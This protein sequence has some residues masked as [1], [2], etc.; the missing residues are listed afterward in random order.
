MIWEN[1]FKNPPAKNRIKPFWFWNGDMNEE[2]IDIQLKEMADKGLGGVFIC[3]RQGLK[4][5]YLSK[6]W[7]ERVKYASERAEEYGLEVWLYDEYPY[8]SGMSGG[9]VLIKNPDAVQLSVSCK[10]FVVENGGEIEFNLGWH[11]ILYAKAFPMKDDCICFDDPIS[12][13]DDIGNLQTQEIYQAQDGLTSYNKK[14]FFTYGPQHILKTRLPEGKWKIMTYHAVAIYDNFKYFGKYFDP[15][16]KEAVKTFIETTHNRYTKYMGEKFGK[17]IFGIFSDEVALFDPIPWSKK[18]PEYFFEKKGYN[19]LDHL[20]ALN[21]SSYPKAYQIRYDF[22]DA[23]NQMFVESYHKQISD[24][25]KENNILYATEVPSRRMSALRYSTVVGG[26]TAHEKLG[27][28]LEWIYDTYMYSYR[29]NAKAI[30]SMTRQLGQQYAMVESFH[31]VGWTMTLQDAKWMFDRLCASGINFYN[32]HAFYYT[33]D[34]LAKHDAPPS[35][36]LQ[37][38]YWKHYRKLSDY[39]GRLSVWISNTEADISVAVLDPTASLWA[40]RAH[41]HVFNLY[42]AEDEQESV[43]CKRIGTD[44]ITICK[45]LLYDQIDYEHLDAEM[46]ET[47][48]I[49]D[50]TISL[51]RAA[52]KVLV[53]PSTPFIEEGAYKKIRAFAESGGKIISLGILPHTIIDKG[54][55]AIDWSDF[56][57]N[58]KPGRI[59]FEDIANKTWSS[60]CEKMAERAFEISVDEPFR[61]TVISSVRKDDGKYYVFLTNQGKESVYITV[62]PIW[63]DTVYAQELFIESG[64]RQKIDVSENIVALRPYESRLLCY[65]SEAENESIITDNECK[66]IVLDTFGELPVSITGGNILR[67]DKFSISRDRKEWYGTTAGTFIEQCS[68]ISIVESGDIKFKQVFAVPTKLNINYPCKV[69]YKAEFEAEYLPEKIGILMDLHA[70]QKT[71]VMT[72]NGKQINTDNFTKVFVNDHS[73]RLCDIS[74]LVQKG[75]N[76]LEIEVEVTK[77]SDG[78]RD[79]L[80]LYGDFGV[81]IFEGGRAIITDIPKKAEFKTNYIEGFPYYSGTV[82][83]K[84]SLDIAKKPERSKIRLDISDQCHE[85]VE[86]LIN[87]KTLG[88]KAFAPYEWE[89]H[90]GI[91]TEGKN[92]VEIR[93][94]NTLAAMLDGTWFDYDKHCLVNI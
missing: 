70:I 32:I 58:E 2:E 73:N 50:G 43:L 86:I 18:F 49:K 7:F 5:P 75:V 51:G 87:G 46:L 81:R 64:M 48:E 8:P 1:E 72:V 34:S 55:E 10:S 28:E 47:A 60:E 89:C 25:C 40:Y 88:V 41:P 36:F 21:C 3:A 44:W 54:E 16:R 19:I 38:P 94:T 69:Y 68:K 76:L 84:T 4:I 23:I 77:D 78:I 39:A 9:E 63:T 26:D 56:G 82:S 52:Y 93:W 62:K 37:N 24:W 29:S 61:K 12:L 92:E 59:H 22:Y 35:H 11:D 53:I 80:Y 91:L 65:T 85:C 90:D 31:S 13:E 45:E 33:L 30:S 6:E 42:A 67:F 15:C 27:R 14:R 79:P 17:T 71:Y 74:S 57:W 83:F 66:D 20:V